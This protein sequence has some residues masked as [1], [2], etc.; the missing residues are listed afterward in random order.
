[1]KQK[2]IKKLLAV[3]AATSLITTLFLAG[4]SGQQE[5][6]PVEETVET[7][8][9]ESKPIAG[10]EFDAPDEIGALG[11]NAIP[12]G[13]VGSF[14][15]RGGDGA[16]YSYVLMDSTSYGKDN[17]CFKIEGDKLIVDKLLE[18]GL[19]EIYVQVSSG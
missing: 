15:A 8:E 6:V 13:V 16:N 11:E 2:R 4:C 12:G 1:M 9:A 19:Y 10:F 7:E 3:M 5:E 14:S 18:P 17:G